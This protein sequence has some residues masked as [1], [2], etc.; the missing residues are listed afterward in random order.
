MVGTQ[1]KNIRIGQYKAQQKR[2]NKGLL[3]LDKYTQLLCKMP[4]INNDN[5][6]NDDDDHNASNTDIIDIPSH[7]SN[8]LNQLVAC[9]IV[10]DDI[11]HNSECYVSCDESAHFTLHGSDS[12]PV[13]NVNKDQ[14]QIVK[15]TP[16]R[17]SLVDGGGADNDTI[18]DEVRYF[19]VGCSIDVIP[20]NNNELKQQY[21]QKSFV[22]A[23]VR[24]KARSITHDEAKTSNKQLCCTT[25]MIEFRSDADVVTLV[26]F[27]ERYG[28][29]IVCTKL[30]KTQVNDYGKVLFE[31]AHVENIEQ[32]ATSIPTFQDIEPIKSID[33]RHERDED[34]K[35]LNDDY[36]L[37]TY[38]FYSELVDV[39]KLA[40]E[41][42]Q[43]C[44]PLCNQ[45]VPINN[46]NPKGNV[47]N[48]LITIQIKNYKRLEA[49]EY[50]DDTLI[51]F[52]MV[53]MRRGHEDFSM[54]HVCP[55]QLYTKLLEP[56]GIEK[57]LKWTRSRNILD[58]KI[59]IIPINL[60]Y[61]PHWQMV[62]VV[63]PGHI[64]AM[65]NSAMR[66]MKKACDNKAPAC[67]MIYFDSVEEIDEKY[68]PQ[69]QL[70]RQWLDREW[71]RK[72][73]IEETPFSKYLRVIR[74]VGTSILM[75]TIV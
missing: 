68:H 75:C 62:A 8:Q 5:T 30:E 53:W 13:D 54:I 4:K 61:P 7:D 69:F 1:K 72:T 17:I 38:P 66:R 20:N 40:K 29:G 14:K 52:M 10:I 43:Q 56:D 28:S 67:F 51:D 25:V 16:F 55:T 3:L 58:R 11:V 48:R 60:I 74:A 36:H 12:K 2:E 44:F 9:Q 34:G 49:K 26:D 18:I 47:G 39:E 27:I 24:D 33:A 37:A 42:L 31:Q 22:Y 6:S 59:I 15:K 35:L 70:I 73:S 23:K 64:K 21:H 65:K 50:L 46:T 57:V 71:S 45:D 19:I 63:N 32:C 41:T